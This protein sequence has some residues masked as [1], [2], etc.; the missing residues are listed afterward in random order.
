MTLFSGDSFK[1]TVAA[2]STPELEQWINSTKLVKL[3][4]R[5]NRKDIWTAL[6]NSLVSV[7][8][9][10]DLYL[11]EGFIPARVYESVIFGTVPISYKVGSQPAL[12][13]NTVSE[14]EEICKF[15]KDCSGADYFKILSQ[16]AD[17]L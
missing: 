3:C 16:I 9:S 1:M 11:K 17:S 15:L 7:N 12:T 6:E 10:K 14:F 5:E 13:F 4:P 2:K 8:V